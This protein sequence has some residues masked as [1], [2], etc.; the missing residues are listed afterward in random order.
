MHPLFQVLILQEKLQEKD[1]EVESLK[2]ELHQKSL[3]EEENT[4]SAADKKAR[5]EVMISGESGN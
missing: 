5:D 2:D 4:N 1:R 3:I